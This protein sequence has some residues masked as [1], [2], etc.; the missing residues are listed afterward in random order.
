MHKT[1][2]D[3]A[4]QWYYADAKNQQQGPVEATWLANAFRQGSVTAGT[5][6]WREGLAA[7][8][9]LS[10]IAN[11]LGLVV[12][13]A[14][15][16]LPAAWTAQ[17]TPRIVKPTSSSSWIIVVFVLLFG[18][19]AVMGILA[20][21]ALPA[22]QDYTMR[23]KVSGALVQAAALKVEVAEFFLTENRCPANG[24]GDFKSAE[25]YAS[26]TVAAIQIGALEIGGEC[27]IQI[28]FRN[29][30][31]RDTEGRHL[32]LTMDSKMQWRSSSD[33]PSKFLPTS[34]RQEISR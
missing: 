20:A 6:V 14:P 21:I 5:L 32:I 15:P 18:F 27:A 11:E 16:A 4:A 28:T 12:V 33:L 26:P 13:G 7:W 1:E 34:M 31:A 23:A 10:Q 25:A 17:A 24:E 8:V 3:M 22:Y 19:V 9:P 30:G 29:I 2:N